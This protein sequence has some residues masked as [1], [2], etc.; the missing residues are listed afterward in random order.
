MTFSCARW[1]STV[2]YVNAIVVF[3]ASLVGCASFGP[4][5]PIAVSDVKSLAGSWKGVVYGYGGASRTDVDMTIR[6]DG[7]YRVAARHGIG[8]S[9]GEGKIL[10]N[11][12][13][14]VIQGVRGEGVA[15]LMSNPAGQRVMLVEMTLFDNSNLSARLW[16]S[17]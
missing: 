10:I 4:L 11:E 12:G 1:R 14:L 2:R 13:R 3:A 17:P 9:H 7:S 15:T 5:S 16:P 8:T 6:E